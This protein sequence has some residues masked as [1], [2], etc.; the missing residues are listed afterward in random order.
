MVS[1][2][3]FVSYARDDDL[4]PPG[5]TQGKGFVATLDDHLHFHFR[6][7]GPPAPKVWRDVRGI[8]PDDQFDPILEKEVGEAAALLIV[9]S[10]NWLHRPYCRREL[11]LFRKR[12]QHEGEAAIKE[13]I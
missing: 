1:F 2:K 12:W 3:V 10:N 5:S 8:E 11:E 9:L 7:L 6:T 4:P 13:R